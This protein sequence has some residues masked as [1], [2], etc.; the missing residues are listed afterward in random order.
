MN[1]NG[2]QAAIRKAG[3]LRTGGL[4]QKTSYP[5]VSKG[6]HEDRFESQDP[7]KIRPPTREQIRARYQTKKKL[8]IEGRFKRVSPL[9]DQSY[10]D[11][12]SDLFLA[13]LDA[14]RE[15]VRYPEE[16]VRH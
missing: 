11:E 5:V 7:C 9:P 15:A 10:R 16:L 1:G 2:E 4:V 8:Y 13:P 14:K 3:Y 12:A 6:P